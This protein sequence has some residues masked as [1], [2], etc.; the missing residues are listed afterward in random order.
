[1]RKLATTSQLKA[2]AIS[3][4]DSAMAAYDSGDIAGARQLW[5]D[6]RN[7]YLRIA[8]KTND[9]DLANAC[10]AL[11]ADCL[12]SAQKGYPVEAPA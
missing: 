6:A 11:A 3:L 2:Y 5:R 12:M 4:E 9:I 10:R 1:M 8:R 7:V